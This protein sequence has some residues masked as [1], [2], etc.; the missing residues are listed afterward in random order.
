MPLPETRTGRSGAASR[1]AAPAVALVLGLAHA[2]AYSLAAGW[3]LQL[4]VLTALLMLVGGGAPRSSRSIFAIAFAFGLGTFCAGVGWLYVSMHR[5][6]GL[7]A[8]LAAAAVLLLSAYLA[9]FGAAAIALAGRLNRH[10]ADSA[11]IVDLALRIYGIG[12]LWALGE[13]A[14]AVVF[15]GFPWLS[16]GY[17]QI[18][19]PIAPLASAVGV[20]GLG[21]IC[22]ALA[23]ALAI[24]LRGGTKNPRATARALALAVLPMLA[25][26][27]SI[28]AT[29]AIVPTGAPVSVRLLQGN[30]GQAM[31]FDPS[32]ALAAMRD[33]SDDVVSGDAQLTVLPETAWTVTWPATPPSIARRIIDHLH[34]TGGVMALG[35]PMIAADPDRAAAGML[36]NSVAVFDGD[37]RLVGRYDKRHLVPFGEYVPT[38]FGWF[39]AMMR[40]PLGE[41]ARG[42]DHQ[43]LLRLDGQSFAFDVCYEDLFP[44][45]L[46]RQVLAGATVL[47]NVS[48]IGWF[49]D[50]HALGQH[51][52]ISRMRAIELG[53]PMLRA[54][55]TGMTAAIDAHG[56]VLAALPPV[57]R[58]ALD[59][60]V[61]G[62]AGTTPF[63]RFGSAPAL[64]A[65]LVV[66]AA[67]LVLRRRRPRTG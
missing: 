54:T 56:Q 60:V 7:P 9:L 63:T 50:S 12:A 55:N 29:D 6:G 44:S 53:R 15:T 61:R 52:K 33:Y 20:Y 65:S 32:R 39:V 59:V 3:A 17:A 46:R 27:V 10:R 62:A 48:N 66:A 4:A 16:V 18:D 40:I 11:R 5:F 8:P 21:G 31:K 57:S 45:L 41:F 34:E 13:M 28:S 25:A 64:V 22:V 35:L 19:G 58:G 51:L 49:G 24:A 36:S 2:A 67:L 43:A 30:V 23:A 1:L 14:R 37:G 38:G 26:A 47:V 42:A